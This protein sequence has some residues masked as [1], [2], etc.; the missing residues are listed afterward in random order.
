MH[1]N[2]FRLG[3]FWNPSSSRGVQWTYIHSCFAR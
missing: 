2:Y 3:L 1:Q